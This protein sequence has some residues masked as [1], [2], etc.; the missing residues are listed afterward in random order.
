MITI[1][2]RVSSATVTVD[3]APIAQIN[4]GILALIAIEKQDDEAHA[5]RLL[6]R[7]LNYR[8]FSDSN[9]R[10]NLSLK[11]IDAAYYSSLNSRLL[12]ILTVVIVLASRRQHHLNAAKK[13]LII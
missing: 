5:D 6:Q 2:Q 7:L 4:Q 9:D 11:Q 1:I 13:C 10:M 3:D 12:Q 8:V